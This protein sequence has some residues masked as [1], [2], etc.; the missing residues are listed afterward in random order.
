MFTKDK[1]EMLLEDAFLEFTEKHLDCDEI[2]ESDSKIIDYLCNT[3]SR[4]RND[5]EDILSYI[6]YSHEKIAFTSGVRYAMQ[7]AGG[8]R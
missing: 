6:M 8:F 2:R 7:K 4:K 3:S 1:T 5:I